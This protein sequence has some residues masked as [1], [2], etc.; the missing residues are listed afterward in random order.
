M[1][2]L[3]DD[4]ALPGSTVECPPPADMVTMGDEELAAWAL[5]GCYRV[6]TG[7]AGVQKSAVQDLI[8]LDSGA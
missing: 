7:V 6:N 2:W 1:R 5:E 3:P 4:Y 8:A